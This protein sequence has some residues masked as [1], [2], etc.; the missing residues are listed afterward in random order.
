VKGAPNSGFLSAVLGRG[1]TVIN[2][3]PSGLFALGKP[4]SVLSHPNKASEKSRSLLTVDYDSVEQCYHW[5]DKKGVD[6]R[7]WLLHRL[8][9][10]TS[11]VV[12]VASDEDVARAVRDGFE[13]RAVQKTYVAIVLGHPREKRAEWHDKLKVTR[14]SGA[15]RAREGGGLE[16]H[17]SMRRVKLL[18]GPPALSVL[19]LEPHTGRTHQLRHQCSRRNLPIVGDK[20]YGNFRLNRGL[21]R[22]AKTDRLFL[23]AVRI[24]LDLPVAGKRLKFTAESPLPPA[25]SD[26]A[27]VRVG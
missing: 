5:T 16:A 17:A 21:A 27:G 23:H 8:D 1:V 26:L 15:V 11:G 22:R 7:V 2:S 25:F 12:L 18:P 20:T 6:R 3:H 9:S 19:E 14:A 24:R 10:A 4:S 13:K